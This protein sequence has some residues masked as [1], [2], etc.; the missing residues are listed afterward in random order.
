MFRLNLM[1][2]IKEELHLKLRAEL[3]VL[4]GVR[5][6]ESHETNDFEKI[7]QNYKDKG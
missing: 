3:E 4:L 2:Q 1:N 6:S 5:H 7:L